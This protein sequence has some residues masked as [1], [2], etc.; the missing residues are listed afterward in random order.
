MAYNR[1]ESINLR[2]LT[3]SDSAKTTLVNISWAKVTLTDP[4]GNVL[5]DDQE[6]TLDDTGTYDYSYDI[7]TDA[8]LGLYIVKWKARYLAKTTIDYS[9][10][11]VEE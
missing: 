7:A 10:F 3:Y 9:D 6:A 1:E 4:E 8:P 2:L 5:I 11:A